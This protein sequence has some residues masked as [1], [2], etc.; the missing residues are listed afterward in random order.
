VRVGLARGRQH[1]AKRE[2][3][4]VCNTGPQARAP[5]PLLRLTRATHLAAAAAACCAL[6]TFLTI[7]CSSIRK[8]RTI[9]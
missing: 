8:A 7:F 1:A 2:H 5:L 4:C 6:S 9:L 3:G